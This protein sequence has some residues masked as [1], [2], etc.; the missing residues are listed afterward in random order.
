MGSNLILQ[1]GVKILIKNEDNKYLLVRRSLIKYPGITGRWD[2]VGGRIKPGDT[3]INNLKREIAE[4]A[5]LELVGTPKL[6]AAQ[7]ILRKAGHHIIRLT[8][9][10]AAQGEIKL[11]TEENDLYQWYSW[12]ELLSLDDVDAYFK[13]LLADKF[14]SKLLQSN[15]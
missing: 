3:L 12:E 9:L 13:E 6:I 1:V 2:I 14:F 4:E 10:G 5:G 11:D 15:A 8:Y 7:D